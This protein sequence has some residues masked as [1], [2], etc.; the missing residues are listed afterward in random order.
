MRGQ[1]GVGVDRAEAGPV[2]WSVFVG[3]Q[4]RQVEGQ[5]AAVCLSGPPVTS[6]LASAHAPQFAYTLA[7]GVPPQSI[8]DESKTLEEAG[9][10]NAVIIQRK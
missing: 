9:L 5:S 7:S 1:L 6:L 3:K 10:L 8:T 2:H 4:L